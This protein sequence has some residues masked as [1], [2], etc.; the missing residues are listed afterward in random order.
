ML[1]DNIHPRLNDVYNNLCPMKEFFVPQK[2]DATN[3]DY[4]RDHDNCIKTDIYGYLGLNGR[5][6][7]KKVDRLIDLGLL[8]ERNYGRYNVKRIRITS[9]GRSVLGAMIDMDDIMNGRATTLME[10]NDRRRFREIVV[11]YVS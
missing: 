5:N 3:L 2:Y 10:E 4:V 7:T 1:F 11:P 9:K 6:A 8:E